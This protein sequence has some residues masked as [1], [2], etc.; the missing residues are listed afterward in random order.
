[1]CEAPMGTK[2]AHATGTKPAPPSRSKPVPA[3]RTNPAHASRS[4]PATATGTNPALATGTK[5]AHATG[6]KPIRRGRLPEIAG[7]LILRSSLHALAARPEPRPSSESPRHEPSPSPI[8]CPAPGRAPG[9]GLIGRG[10]RPG[11][12]QRQGRRRDR[13]RLVPG[14]PGGEG[15]HHRPDLPGRAAPRSRREP[16]GRR[17]RAGRRPRVHRHPGPLARRAPGRR[18]P[19][20]GQD[21]PGGHHRDPR[22][23]GEQRPVEAVRRPPRVRRLAPGHASGTAARSISARSSARRPSGRTSRG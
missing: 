18:W 7:P 11:H 4:K 23:G 21:H 12:P 9:R 10:L 8:P 2:P 1:M 13:Q 16:Q 20:R 6:T 15:R 5:P 19:A 17:L 14:R 22:R 3:T